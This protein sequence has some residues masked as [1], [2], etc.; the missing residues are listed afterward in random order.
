M[1]TAEKFPD[2]LLYIFHVEFH[3]KKNDVEPQVNVCVY[4]R[5]RRENLA[6]KIHMLISRIVVLLLFLGCQA[7]NTDAHTHS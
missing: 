5:I 2:N 3:A 6:G 1:E 7:R 4:V